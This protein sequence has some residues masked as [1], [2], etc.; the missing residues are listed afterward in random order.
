M[1]LW[2][3]FKKRGPKVLGT[4][5]GGST[6]YKYDKPRDRSLRELT[7]EQIDA[8]VE[9]RERVYE[10]LFGTPATFVWHETT[11]RA[12]HVDVY[13]YPP[14]HAGRSYFTFITGGMSDLPMYV[15]QGREEVRRAE[16]IFYSAE[17]SDAAIAWLQFLA[18]FPHDFQTWLATG[19]TLP[20]G[21]PPSPLG[22]G[23]R[24][25]TML[26]VESPREPDRTLSERLQIAGE[27]VQ[28][29]WLLPITSAECE[30]KLEHGVEALMARFEERGLP[31]LFDLHRESVV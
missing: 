14:G 5:E 30:Y 22:E 2:D 10:E 24:L 17:P 28:L 9:A 31:L 21:Q 18:H 7:P 11:P 13:S 15:P 20:N 27:P 3:L 29:L 1:G 23:S 12:P 16:I 6:L 25:D 8:G 19:H 4:S 26:L